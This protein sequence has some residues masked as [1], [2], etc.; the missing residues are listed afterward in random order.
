MKPKIKHFLTVMLL[1]V[2]QLA[3]GQEKTITGH[4]SD[5]NGVPIPGVNVTLEGTTKGTVTDFDGNYSITAEEGQTL[6]FSI[7]GFQD[8]DRTVGAENVINVLL[9][10]GTALDQ[11]VVTALGISREKRSLGYAT[12]AVSADEITRTPSANFT[13]ALSGKVSGL[14]IKQN[15]NFGG[16]SDAIIRGVS[17]I[18]GENNALYVIDGIPISNRIENDKSV[19][20]GGGFDYG[21]PAADI[22]PEDIKSINV[23]KGGAAAALYGARAANGVIEIT[24]KGGESTEGI[25]VTVNSGIEF[26][27]LDRSTWVKHQKKFGAGASG[28]FQGFGQDFDG[29]DGVGPTSNFTEDR[30]YGP[31]FDPNVMVYQWDAFDPDSPNY[32]KMTPW[33]PAENGTHTFFETPVVFTNSVSIGNAVEKGN[34]RFSYSNKD[35]KGSMPNSQAVKND[36]RFKGDYNITE[37]FKVGGFA[38]YIKTNTLGRSNP[39]AFLSGFRQ[40][41]TPNVDIKQLKDMYERTGRN[42]TWNPVNTDPYALPKR[43]DNP[44]FDRYENYQNDARSRFIGMLRLDYEVTDWFNITARAGTDTYNTR[45]QERLA[46]G[47]RPMEFGL[48]GGIVN[49]GYQ[50]KDITFYENNFDLLLNFHTKIFE[51]LDFSGLLGGNIRRDEYS[52]VLQSTAGGLAT[53]G[54]YSLQNGAGPSPTPLESL[55]KTGNDSFYG[56]V[57]FGYAKTLYLDATLRN[58][59][60]STLPSDHSSVWYPSVSTSW[61]FSEHLRG[62]SWLNLGKLHVN[63]AEVGN[64]APFDR[65]VDSYRKNKDIGYSLPETHNNED[66]KPERTKSFETGLELEFFNRRISFDIDYYITRSIDQIIEA[67]VGTF[68]GYSNLLLNAGEIENKGVELSLNAIVLKTEDLTWDFTVNWSKNKGMVKSLPEGINSLQ[69]AVFGENVSL[70]AVEGQPFGVL[71]GTDYVYDDKGNHVIKSI[72]DPT[73]KDYGQVQQTDSNTNNIGNITPDWLMGISSSLRWKDLSFGFLID[74]QK[75]GD[76][77]S[78]DNMYGDSSGG[79][80]ATVGINDKGNPIRSPREDG[81]GFINP[82]VL[83]DGTPNDRYVDATLRQQFGSQAYPNSEFIFDAGYVKLRE[84]SITYNLPKKL[85]E[86]TFLTGVQ[87]T[88]TGNNLWIIHKNTVGIDPE[89]GFGAGNYSGYISGAMPSFRMFG[90]NARIQF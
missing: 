38:N 74:M 31:A 61:I 90:F 78:I 87:L 60:F 81:G 39:T 4:V 84:V 80:I 89:S 68:T 11:V 34:Y 50:R 18:T 3:F 86:N 48:A 82:G 49:S 20:E 1:A 52:S 58:D 12:Q 66:L 7:I 41:W 44:Y 73:Q 42:V 51:D 67:P 5:N 76:L 19:Q 28:I 45:Q 27:V 65:L 36:L 71:R 2:F 29:N 9:Q 43:W 32:K 47:A 13:N 24:T 46:V 8:E 35:Q 88:A 25:G 30:A 17:S 75:G 26:G 16:S 63:Y 85:L 55:Q 6:L 79:S 14:Q 40:W 77:L 54:I 70:E 21:N 57:S 62:L 53:P 69:L 59:K 23:L 83:P 33:V 37:N 64:G 56:Q 72:N 22:S 10:E 15:N